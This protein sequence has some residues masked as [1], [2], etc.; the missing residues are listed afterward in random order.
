M[1]TVVASVPPVDPGV[2]LVHHGRHGGHADGDATL[3]VGA[4]RSVAPYSGG[5][6]SLAL[7]VAK[8]AVFVEVAL[9]RATTY[10]MPVRRSTREKA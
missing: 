6:R 8:V 1:V 5:N 9:L 7:K 3:R 2:G 10:S 4:Q